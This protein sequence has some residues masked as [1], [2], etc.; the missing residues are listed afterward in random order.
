MCPVTTTTF[1]E[2]IRENGL[3][4]ADQVDELSRYLQPRFNDP[5]A[6]A[7]YLVQR[8]WLTVY[9][10]NQ[11]LQEQGKE[12]ILGAYRIL[13]CLGEGAISQVFKAWDTRKKCTVALK[14]LYP[15]LVSQTRAERQFQR[16]IQV[17]SGLKH[18]N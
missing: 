16:E 9:Q 3:L 18:P 2:D 6:L 17:L 13:D 15:Y 12:L 4:L 1:V 8:R 11:L 5:S 14:V 7:K 10:I